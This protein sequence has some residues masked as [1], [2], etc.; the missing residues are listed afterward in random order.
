[1]SQRLVIWDRHYLKGLEG[2][3]GM[4]LL[5]EVCHWGGF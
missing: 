5:K 3:G 1:M 4:A 2:L